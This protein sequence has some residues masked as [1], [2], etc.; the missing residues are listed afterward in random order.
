MCE[1]CC[2]QRVM[3]H[4]GAMPRLYV[5]LD[6]GAVSGGKIG[7]LQCRNSIMLWQ[8][9]FAAWRQWCWLLTWLELLAECALSHG[10]KV[11]VAYTCCLMYCVESLAASSSHCLVTCLLSLQQHFISWLPLYHERLVQTC[12]RHFFPY[13]LSKLDTRP[14]P[15]L[16]SWSSSV[17]QPINQRILQ[18]SNLYKHK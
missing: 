5:E 1:H 13:M 3:Q 2:G 18:S 15:L 4:V 12:S 11:L 6:F 10:G 16:A 14:L 17:G 8:Y 9:D 7:G